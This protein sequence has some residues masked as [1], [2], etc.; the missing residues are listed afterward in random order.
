MSSPNKRV[1]YCILL[2]CHLLKDIRKLEAVQRRFTKKAKKLAGF[3]N[4]SLLRTTQTTGLEQLEARPTRA[5]LVFTYKF[6]FGSIY[7]DIHDFFNFR[8]FDNLTETRG[9]PYKLFIPHFSLMHIN[10]FSATVSLPA[11][12]DA[13]I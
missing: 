7:L 13:V 12:T 2:Y 8:F 9:H 5:D 1:L 11:N 10:T 3:K 6:L 4:T